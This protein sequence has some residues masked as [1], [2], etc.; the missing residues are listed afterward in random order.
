MHEKQ[1]CYALFLSTSSKSD[2]H[3]RHLTSV[4]CAAHTRRGCS[5]GLAHTSQKLGS[6][7]VWGW[8]HGAI[9]HSAQEQCFQAV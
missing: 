1:T 4:A 9:H 5:R 2:V 7:R 6:C 8:L 3:R